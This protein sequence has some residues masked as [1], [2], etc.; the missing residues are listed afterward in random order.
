MTLHPERLEQ[1][2]H[3]HRRRLIFV[4]SMSDLF[5]KNIPGEFVDSVSAIQPSR[6]VHQLHVCALGQP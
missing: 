3:W 5:H 6:K 1:S 2:R 4:N